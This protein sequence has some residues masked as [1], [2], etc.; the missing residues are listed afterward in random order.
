MD[1]ELQ[2]TPYNH[3]I[4]CL[5][6]FAALQRKGY[7]GRGREIPV[8]SVS[9]ALTAVSQK[10]VLAHEVNPTKQRGSDK[11]APRIA[12]MLAGWG[13]EDPATIKKL[14]VEA[15]VPELLALASLMKGTTELQMAIGDCALVAFYYL[16][17]VGE[18]TVKKTRN[19]TKQI[20]QFELKDCTFFK[21]NAMGQLRQLSR[22]ASDE[23]IMAA[24]SAT[25]KLDNSKNG[26]KGVCVNQEANG[27]AHCCAVRAIGRRY[28]YIRQ[29]AS[30]NKAFLSAY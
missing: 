30:S 2:E 24:D 21:R 5:T 1:P 22:S 18:Y 10:I 4:R 7:Y 12:E 25:L 27:E 11:F 17:R 9:S 6:G 19:H 13:K 8:G 15:N 14:P 29:H 16:C 23:D 28:C 3:R 20:K 26:W